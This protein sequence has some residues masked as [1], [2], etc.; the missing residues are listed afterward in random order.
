MRSTEGTGPVSNMS[1]PDRDAKQDIGHVDLEISEIFEASSQSLS[2]SE[3]GGRG[4]SGKDQRLK[5][6]GWRTVD[7]KLS[8]FGRSVFIQ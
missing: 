4:G 5:N 1:H 6:R 3:R 7:W 8:R 2:C